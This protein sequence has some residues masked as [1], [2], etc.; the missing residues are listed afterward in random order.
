M[1]E[2]VFR[3]ESVQRVFQYLRRRKA[4][5]D[6]DKFKLH[7]IQDKPEG[8]VQ[9]CLDCILSRFDRHSFS[10]HFISMQ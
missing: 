9:E 6:L 2:L 7:Y 1:D 3:E 5:Q 4:K 10:I 8:K